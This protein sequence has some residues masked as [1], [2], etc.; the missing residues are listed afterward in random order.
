[1]LLILIGAGCFLLG[2]AF[3]FWRTPSEL[4]EKGR[5]SVL[6]FLAAFIAYAGLW[7]SALAAAWTSYWPLP[8]PDGPALA[9][10]GALALVGGTVYLAARLQFRSFRLTWG[11]VADRLVTTGLYRFSRN[12]QLVGWGLLFLGVAVLGRSGAGL[13]LAT[14][15]SASCLVSVPLEERAL[16]R[17]YGAA[18]EAFRSSVPR[19][20]G[21]PRRR[22]RLTMAG[23]QDAS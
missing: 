21:L 18:Y 6:T 9:L 23:Q 5:T 3:A 20:F 1:M 4:A 12:P 15:F 8:I 13:L 16:R 14:M 19:F 11:L 17:R 7:L 22:R 2:G 10:G